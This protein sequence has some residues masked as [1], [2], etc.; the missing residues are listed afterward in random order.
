MKNLSCKDFKIVRARSATKIGSVGNQKSKSNP[1]INSLKGT[2][3]G[4][5]KTSRKKVFSGANSINSNTAKAKG[6]RFSVRISL[7]ISTELTA[8]N[9]SEIPK[10]KML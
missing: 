5:N 6:I 2:E 8:T 1:G 9:S 7:L 10:T 3:R 4:T